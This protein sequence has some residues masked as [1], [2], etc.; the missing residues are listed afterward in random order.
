MAYPYNSTSS[1]YPNQSSLYSQSVY[2]Q[3]SLGQD[4]ASSLYNSQSSYGGS[5]PSYPHGSQPALGTTG[6]SNTPYPQPQPPTAMSNFGSTQPIN[7]A[8]PYNSYD[9][10]VGNQ[11]GPNPQS[12]TSSSA[13]GGNQHQNTSR[14]NTYV[15]FTMLSVS[16]SI[17]RRL[18]HLL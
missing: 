11:F 1:S 13:Y 6:Y 16:K 14:Y 15:R 18:T 12:Y 9:Q 17:Y 5:P 3:N 7:Q 8:N 2:G 4:H 10:R